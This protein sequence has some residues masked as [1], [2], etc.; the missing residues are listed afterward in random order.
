MRSSEKCSNTD[1][2]AD[3]NEC[4]MSSDNG[5]QYKCRNEN[6]GFACD[7]PVGFQLQSDGK[8]CSSKLTDCGRLVFL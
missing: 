3:L 7:C 5:C 1:V 4:E 6:G 2:S 8:N